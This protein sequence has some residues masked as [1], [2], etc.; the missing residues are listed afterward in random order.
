MRLLSLRGHEIRA[1]DSIQT[2]LEVFKEGPFDV[3][4]S[5]ISLQDG[6]GCDLVRRLLQAQPSLFA[7]AQRGHFTEEEGQRCLQAGFRHL[8]CKPF[9][10]A[11]LQSLLDEAAQQNLQA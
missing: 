5:D 7:I 6:D 2:A 9:S 11:S 3:L 10:F 1:A 8:L 4:I